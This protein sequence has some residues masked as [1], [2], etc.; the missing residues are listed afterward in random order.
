MPILNKLASSLGR[1]DE[2]PN[3]ELARKIADKDDKKAVAELIRLLKDKSRDVQHDSIKVL[4]EIGA[5]KPA[6][7]ASYADDFV[8]LLNHKS[9]RMQ[10]GA[11]T[12]I[13]SIA[14][15]V[16]E[17]VYQSISYIINAADKGSVITKDQCVSILI[18]LCSVT[19]YHDNAFALLIGQLKSSAPNQLPMYAENALPIVKEKGRNIF[20]KTLTSRLEDVEK[21][22][23]KKRIE[24]VLSKL[25]S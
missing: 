6:L 12:A 7:I 5:L 15:E 22:S 16:P 20:I 17:K 2:I 11:M 1:K 18:K 13:S 3:V 21:E 9:N 25:E 8:E 23:K 24:K 4:Y 10:W 19:R 14:N